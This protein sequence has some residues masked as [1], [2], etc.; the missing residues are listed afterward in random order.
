M[1]FNGSSA[2]G[3]N[4]SPVGFWTDLAARFGI[5]PR[6]FTK[7]SPRLIA[8][9]LGDST[10]ADP[11]A[12]A[13]SAGRGLRLRLLLRL[14]V[15]VQLKDLLLFDIIS[16]KSGTTGSRTNQAA[17]LPTPSQPPANRIRLTTFCI[18]SRLRCDH[19]CLPAGRLIM[20]ALSGPMSNPIRY[21]PYMYT[22]ERQGS[23]RHAC[24]RLQTPSET[25][26]GPGAP[27]PSRSG[28]WQLTETP[29]SWKRSHS[30]PRRL[31]RPVPA[32]G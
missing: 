9:I 15:L 20:T 25:V 1:E 27:S 18:D 17:S 7:V 4:F 24:S 14:I 3:S 13:N 30:S 32:A 31:F 21:T 16:F 29:P 26:N 12:A 8:H 19:S 10:T 5:W 23:G 22:L 6:S 2:P 28:Q 11:I